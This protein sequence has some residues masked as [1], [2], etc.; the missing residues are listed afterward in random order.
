M[1]NIYPPIDKDLSN[2]PITRQS[3]ERPAFI[4]RLNNFVLNEILESHKDGLYGLI[5]KTIYLEKQR[6]KLSPWKVDPP[7]DKEYWNSI[8]QEL[9]VSQNLEE[10]H[11]IQLGLLKRIINRYNNE[12]VPHFKPNTFK[13]GR[14]FLT[15]FFS[16][17][18]N[19]YFDKGLIRWGSKKDLSKKII[20]KGPVD[21]IRDLYH[22]GTLVMVPTHYSNLDSIMIGYAIDTNL[23]LPFF[24]YGAG[25]NLLN[26]EIV[27]Y[28]IDRLGAFRVDRRKK[29]PIYLEC[30]KSMTSFSVY[31]G[32]NCLFFP[33]GTR[34]RSGR[35][36]DKLKLG[37]LGSV[38]EAQRMN[39][40]EDNQQKIFLIPLCVGYHFVLEAPS[41]VDQHLRAIG[42]EQYIRS[43]ASKPSSSSLLNFIK[44]I[45]SKSSEVYMSFGE[46][47]DVLGNEVDED[48]NS[49]D[50]FGRPIQVKDYF[51]SE[52][53][54]SSDKQRDGV[55]AKN[56]AEILVKS[57]KKNN[58][59]L[60]SNVVAFTAFHLI[61]SEF[62]EEGFINLIN[63]KN[64]IYDID[65]GIF[66]E[67][68]RE[69]VQHI[70]KMHKNGE[71]AI[72][73]E[74]WTEIEVLIQQ[75]LEKGGIYHSNPVLEIAKDNK[76]ICRNFSLLY[77][78]H[79]RLAQYGLE[80]LMGWQAVE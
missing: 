41:L 71:V 26:N 43:S 64:K 77:F 44:Q 51:I 59:I 14:L 49:I 36:E 2:W 15:S 53:G 27:G 13:F 25:L 70:L 8:S 39:I 42:K 33:G 58:V 37:L 32:L 79:N 56:L 76:I 7:D 75:G 16:R 19:K 9:E 78:Y 47:L 22:K 62:K 63:K 74:H 20:L 45:Y 29:N 61:N 3:N 54:L 17:I 57:Y 30:L 72:S 68:V 5:S 60:S 6:I 69:L 35:T 38:I 10:K 12:I 50:K 4:G 28:F 18:F 66:E 34:S 48:G 24:S 1:P 21:K 67:K 40:E 80:N 23:G 52:N 65:Y 11:E 73:D 55:Y 31:E 46:P